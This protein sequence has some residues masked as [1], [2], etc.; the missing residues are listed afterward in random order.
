MKKTSIILSFISIIIF[1]LFLLKKINIIEKY[2][3]KK[4]FKFYIVTRFSILDHK[5]KH[6]D[7]T[8]HDNNENSYKKKLF[9][10]ERLSNKFKMFE[11]VTLPSINNQTYKNYEWHIYTSPYLPD[12]YK[13]KL[14][15][16]TKNN[17]KIKIFYVNS[18]NEMKNKT[19]SFFKN[20]ENYATL[21]L[22]D[23]DGLNKKFLLN[24]LKYKNKNGNIISCPNGKKY[25][26]DNNNIILGKNHYEKN[27]AIGLTAINKNIYD[28][29]S[30]ENINKNYNTIYDDLKDSYLL[31]TG[32]S[33]DTKREFN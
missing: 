30:H 18:M 4:D 24:L 12:K 6:W 31:G 25:K 26:I 13:K 8:K 20:K 9:S 14:I 22:D 33:T 29:G 2:N 15:N 3:E 10:E 7:Y 23:D 19:N 11:K 17:N 16:I 32:K 28:C 5:A 27:I 1:I 21:R